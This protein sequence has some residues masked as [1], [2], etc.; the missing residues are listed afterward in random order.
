[1]S[2]QDTTLQNHPDKNLPSQLP[3]KG[4]AQKAEKYIQQFIKLIH[5]AKISIKHT[6]LSRFDPSSLEDHYWFDLES[7][8]VEISHSKQPDSGR[9]SYVIIFNN[10]KKIAEGYSEKV[11]LAYMHLESDQF[12]KFK[13]VADDQIDRIRKAEEEKKLNEVLEPINQV[14]DSLKENHSS[15]PDSKFSNTNHSFQNSQ[16]D[17]SPSY[18]DHTSHSFLELSKPAQS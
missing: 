3:P 7:Y 4:D 13:S 17:N 10:L 11:I 18:N 15:I 8:Q 12:I 5:E 16:T 2:D 1:M 6:D 9:D 14:L